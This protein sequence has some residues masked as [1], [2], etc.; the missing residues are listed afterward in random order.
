MA[1]D[2]AEQAG[3]VEASV[4]V[5]QSEVEAKRIHEEE[6]SRKEA[7]ELARKAEQDRKDE[8]ERRQAEEK[9]QRDQESRK[10]QERQTHSWTR[11]VWPSSRRRR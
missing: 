11:L 10:E 7:E 6:S 9:A 5:S 4:N 3:G 1:Q 2:D 8:S